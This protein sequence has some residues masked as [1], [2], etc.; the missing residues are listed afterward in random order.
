VQKLD[1]NNNILG[2]TVYK[3]ID[4]E[5]VKTFDYIY[6]KG[7]RKCIYSATI[8]SDNIVETIDE[9]TY[10]ENGNELT[11][12]RSVLAEGKW[13][14]YES[15]YNN[16][17]SR[18]NRKTCLKTDNTFDFKCEY[19]YDEN[20]KLLNEIEYT[21]TNDE[22]VYSKKTE[23][24]YDDK[25]DKSNKK[26]YLYRSGQWLLRHEYIYINNEEKEVLVIV[27]KGVEYKSKTE[28]KY[29]ENG[30]MVESI[31]YNFNYGDWQS[32][33]SI[34]N[35]YDENGNILTYTVY[36]LYGLEKE[37]YLKIVYTYD[38]T[39]K[40]IY[41][42]YSNGALKSYEEFWYIDDQWVKKN[43]FILINGIEQMVYSLNII[44][45][46][47]NSKDEMTYDANGNLLTFTSYKP[48]NGEWV[49][50]MENETIYDASGN[51]I[52]TVHLEYNNELVVG[53]KYEFTR[54]ESGDV[55]TRTYYTF[56]N[57]E[58]VKNSEYIFING[59]ELETYQMNYIEEI[60]TTVI[61]EN[62]YNEIGKLIFGISIGYNSNN[63]ITSGVKHELTYDANGNTLSHIE[64]KYENNGWI[65]NYKY[66]YTYDTDGN[67][68]TFI[69]YDF[70]NGEWVYDSKREK[71][72][73][74]DG[75]LFTIIES[76][77]VDNEWVYIEKI[78]YTD[79][80]N[81]YAL[82]V[83]RYKYVNNEW[84]LQ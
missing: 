20:G 16:G 55:L 7:V 79:Y 25:G 28:Y 54:N 29:D 82:N 42:Y 39:N 72:Y 2:Y 73:D 58:W 52:K 32:Y 8:N 69:Y 63:E 64:S 1:E 18:L 61:L 77:Y 4:E 19:T 65:Y 34:E 56:S 10:D 17:E 75:N 31:D 21:Y 33:R 60:E 41:Y 81:G 80:K 44:D 14:I 6:I 30:N 12:K 84:V 26:E 57:D 53:Y 71:T 5:W 27:Y 70:I 78:E 46:Q 47:I 9:Y 35:E 22:W 76:E 68:L 50:T 24:T 37:I 45:D 51:I 13:T 43:G 23:Y 40:R 66:E 3:F 83:K 36:N 74:D 49:K 38:N 67:E 15:I 48:I 62:K 59:N 11:N